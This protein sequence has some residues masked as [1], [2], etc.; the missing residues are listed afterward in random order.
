MVE[1]GENIVN[2]KFK[3]SEENREENC[4]FIEKLFEIIKYCYNLVV[5]V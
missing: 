5:C 1:F 4:I 3:M 2:D